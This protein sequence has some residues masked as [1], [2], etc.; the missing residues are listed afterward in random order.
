MYDLPSSLLVIIG[1]IGSIVI[2]ILI[3]RVGHKTYVHMGG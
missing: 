1:N 3:A 2:I